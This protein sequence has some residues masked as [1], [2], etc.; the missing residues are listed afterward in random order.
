MVIWANHNVRSSVQAMK[1]T[2]KEIYEQQR[3][4]RLFPLRTRPR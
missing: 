3:Y 2:T 4:P 1:D